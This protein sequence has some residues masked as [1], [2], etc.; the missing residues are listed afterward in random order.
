M[1]GQLVHLVY[2]RGIGGAD[3]NPATFLFKL[4]LKFKKAV[5]PARGRHHSGTLPSKESG[6][7]TTNSA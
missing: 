6:G 2:V 5:F 4:P 3:F 7:L 1:F